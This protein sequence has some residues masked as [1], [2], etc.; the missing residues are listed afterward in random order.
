M[1]RRAHS[2]QRLRRQSG[3]G[4]MGRARARTQFRV[5]PLPRA[6]LG[7]RSCFLHSA[8]I[9]GHSCKKQDLTPTTSSVSSAFV[10][11]L[12]KPRTARR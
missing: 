12:V 10:Q 7:V 1:P 4:R 5:P 11:E 3:V 9:C 8:Y 2:A 6:S